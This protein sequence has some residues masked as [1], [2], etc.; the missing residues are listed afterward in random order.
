[1][2]ASAS[3]EVVIYIFLLDEHRDNS[4]GSVACLNGARLERSQDCRKREFE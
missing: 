2:L 1:M 4:N 3:G